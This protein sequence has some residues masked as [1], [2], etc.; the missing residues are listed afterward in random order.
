MWKRR[1]A[2]VLIFVAVLATLGVVGYAKPEHKSV[3]VNWKIAG[4][5]FNGIQVTTD[6]MTGQTAPFGLLSLSAKGSPGAA[7]IEAVGTSVPVAVS[8]LCPDGTDLQLEFAGGFVATFS[9]LSMLFFVIDDASD[10]ENALCVD[11]QGPATGVFDYLVT[12][13]TDRFEGATGSVTVRVTSWS[14]GP[15]L[16]AESGEIVGAIEL[17]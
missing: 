12:G 16:S 6:P 14:V 13:G 5:I 10:A 9:D 17:P 1:W 4:S 7:R 15:A 11:Y 2:I 3:P 8:D